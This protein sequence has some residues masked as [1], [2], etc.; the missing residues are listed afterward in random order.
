MNLYNGEIWRSVF[1]YVNNIIIAKYSVS[2]YGRIRN[3]VTGNIIKL[4]KNTDG[5]CVVRL[6]NNGQCTRFLVGRLVAHLYVSNND[7]INNTVINYMDNDKSNNYFDNLVW[8]NPG[9]D[10]SFYRKNNNV[11]LLK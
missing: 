1:D 6:I 4:N 9:I 3:E 5:F 2:N 8:A 7:L 11:C 10:S